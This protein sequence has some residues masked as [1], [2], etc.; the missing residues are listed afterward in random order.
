ML[1]KMMQNIYNSLFLKKSDLE[2]LCSIMEKSE[3]QLIALTK[4]TVESIYLVPSEKCNLSCRYCYERVKDH[5][6][7]ELGTAKKIIDDTFKNN[8]KDTKIKIDFRGGEPF[9]EFD[10]I[11]EIC[12]WVIKKYNSRDFSF[13]AVTNGTC[14]TD[15]SKKWLIEHKDIFNAPLSIDGNKKTHDYNRSNSF[16][17]IDFDFFTDTWKNPES[18]TTFIP[19]NA[20]DIFDDLIFLVKKGFSM[21]VNFEA[22]TE[23]SDEQLKTVSEQLK[24]LADYILKNNVEYNMN[25]LSSAA[26]H[27]YVTEIKEDRR[28]IQICNAGKNRKIYD[29]TGNKF[30][31]HTMV[32]S[33]FNQYSKDKSRDINELLRTEVLNP[34]EC[35]NCRFFY[36]CYICLGFSYSFA[37]DF[38][39]RNW[40]F[41]DITKIRA[42]FAAY[43]WGK[44]LIN[45]QDSFNSKE[46]AIA[47]DIVKLYRGECIE[48]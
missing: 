32:N 16:D 1:E 3:E 2:F 4:S 40:S 43:Y 34:P 17:L 9:L 33:V 26:F 5:K 48:L 41:C 15:E 7:M 12:E 29:A 8:K 47:Y 28:F 44:Y 13:S 46:K 27:D 31:C 37:G 36:L 35:C 39:Y 14:F 22:I 10:L 24:N 42:F 6:R 38:K 30:P 25:I 45:K 19:E 18:F 11:K 21:R 20:D 23:W